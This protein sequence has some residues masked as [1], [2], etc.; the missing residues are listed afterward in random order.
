[1]EDRKPAQSP[2]VNHNRSRKSK[3]KDRKEITIEIH[4]GGGREP[5]RPGDGGEFNSD[6]SPV[7]ILIAIEN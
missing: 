4:D 2:V 3:R 1:M 7:V 5:K 6:G